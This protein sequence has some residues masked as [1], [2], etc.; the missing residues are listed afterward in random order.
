MHVFI[1]KNI[2]KGIWRIII[3]LE[4]L[5]SMLNSINPVIQFTMEVSCNILS[6]LVIEVNKNVTLVWKDLNSKPT[7]AKGYVPFNSS[8]PKHCLINIPF[9]LARRICMI[10]EN[11][12]SRTNKLKELKQTLRRQKYPE[13][14][15]ENGIAKALKF[16]QNDLRKNKERKESNILPFI[17]TY[18]PNNPNV[19][20]NKHSKP[21]P[22][23]A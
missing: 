12:K 1:L 17:S 20:P 21:I 22:R 8:H 10:V 4:D 15:I 2:G 23:Q 13:K 16:S 6:F 5:L 14:I 19:T 3:S 11:E 7:D 18:N 9:S